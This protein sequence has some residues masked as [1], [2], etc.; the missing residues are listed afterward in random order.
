MRLLSRH[1][2]AFA[3]FLHGL[4]LLPTPAN[5]QIT[6]DPE[7]LAE[8][9]KIKA[10]DNHAH[11]RRVINAGEIDDETEPASATEPLDIP[12]RLRPD[13]AEYLLAARAL[14]GL[15]GNA[16]PDE[17]AVARQRITKERGDA[18]PVWVLDQLGID[19]MFTNRIAMGRGLAAPRFRWV[20]FADPLVFPLDNSVASAANPDNLAEYT[21]IG[22]LLKR[23]LKE[24]GTPELPG[25]L[26]AYLDKVV[27]PTLTRQKAAGAIALKFITAYLRPLDFANPSEKHAQE[28]YARFVKGGAPPPADYKALQDFLF[29]HMA[30]KAG[31]LALP[32]HIHVGAGASGYFNQTGANPFLLEPVL[33]DPGLRGTKF[34]LVHGGSPFAQE[35]R[36][37]LYKPNVYADFSA[38]TFLLSTRELS[39]VLRSWLEFVPEKVLFGTDA[40]EITPEA[41]WPE[42]AWMT[43]RS[44]REA[45]ALALTGMMK[46]GQI[47]R[48]RALELARLVMRENTAKLHGLDER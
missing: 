4:F 29:R 24:A 44:A 35:T 33:N 2:I 10:I 40:F 27:D 48:D 22:R 32:L 30:R 1:S 11:P 6:A 18:F 12:V 34:V 31:A 17:A 39:T 3:I 20:P 26:E 38:Q 42:H 14:Y 43:T 7:L 23:Y 13:N 36:M 9:N 15:G 41:G 46:D 25:T 5:A 21:G 16:S 37:L 8:I 45:L 28:T 47:T 19:V